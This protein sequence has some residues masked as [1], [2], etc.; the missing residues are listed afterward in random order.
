MAYRS[1][2]S[3]GRVD[4]DIYQETTDRIVAQLDAGIVPWVCPWDKSGAPL[5]VPRNGSSLRPYSGINILLLWLAAGDNGF[6]TQDWLTFKQ[7]QEAG[8]NV[9]KGSKGTHIVYADRFVPKGE[10]ARAA[11]DGN[12]ARA[13]F[14]LKSFV[15]FNRDQIEGLGEPVVNPIKGEREPV[16]AGELLLASSGAD[17]RIGGNSAFYAPGDDFIQIPDQRQFRAQ[18]DFYRTAAHELAHW[19]GHKSRL[20][21]KLLN[22]FGSKDYA[23]EELV[24]EM[25]AAFVCASLGIVPTVRHADYLAAWLKVL[26]E[27]K[28]A[29]FQAA[30]LASKAADFLLA[31]I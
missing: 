24:A 21:R 20:D 15:V 22:P 13:V 18:I 5:G 9:R 7:A 23:R 19:T 29:I 1:A 3:A 28:R 16:E 25:G 27:D 31:K 10:Q 4:R 2:S 6:A 26:R 14:F 17:V 30:S 8:G 12:D 11:K